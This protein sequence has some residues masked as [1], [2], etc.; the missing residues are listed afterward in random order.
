MNIKLYVGKVSSDFAVKEYEQNDSGEQVPIPG[1]PVY[2]VEFEPALLTKKEYEEL[3]KKT[4]DHV[5]EVK[6]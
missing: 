2:L 6:A 5:L 4:K 1:D 3:I